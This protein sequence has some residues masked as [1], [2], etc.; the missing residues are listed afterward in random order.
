MARGERPVRVFGGARRVRGVRSG[1]LEERHSGSVG[2]V[3]SSGHVAG[4][5]L[6]R[7]YVHVAGAHRV[8]AARVGRVGVGGGEGERVRAGDGRGGRRGREVERARRERVA[9]G[10]VGAE[11]RDGDAGGRAAGGVVVAG[12]VVE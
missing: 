4:N 10:G 11:R 2:R 7:H 8:L 6:E 12:H 3:S 1:L 9:G 5:G